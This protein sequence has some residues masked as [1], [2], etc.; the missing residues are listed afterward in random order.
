MQERL[1]I[2]GAG[3]IACGL[4]ATAARA[5]EVVLW[6]RSDGSARRA[7]D[8]VAKTLAKLDNGEIDPSRV[9]VVT[10]L[11]ALADSTF[12]VEAVV[13]DHGHK[14]ALLADLARHASAEA[15][16]ATTTSSLSIAAL[17]LAAGRP[18]RFVG[19]HVFNPVP[20]MKL[21]E[22][23]FPDTASSDTRARAQALC[24][25]LEKTAVEVPDIPGFVV[26]R[27]LFPYL[28]SAVELM[29][30]TGLTPEDVDNCMT[31]G[32]GQPMGPLAL[33]DFVGLDVSQAIGET[34][35]A[36][37]PATLRALVAEGSLGRKSG[38]G[39]YSYE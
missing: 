15:V 28:F 39:F 29:T 31:L 8:K 16:L 22:L 17:A 26:N 25:S 7:R 32:A 4:A 27:L 3:A 36:A 37:V 9:T 6:A 1:G 38:Q 21:I 20:R 5:G 14:A 10:D 35:G 13:E 2:A 23:V 30:E 11:A 12:L 33:L 34:I 24:D 19:L 18:D